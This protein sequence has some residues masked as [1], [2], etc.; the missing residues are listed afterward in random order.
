M[1]QTVVG[2]FDDRNDAQHAVRD[3]LDNKFPSDRI[4]IITSDPHGEFVHQKVDSE[5]GTHAAEG[6]V[7]GAVAG[8][9]VGG[10][11]GA[12]VGAGTLF[13]PPLGLIAAGPVAA[14]LAGAGVGAVG[15]GVLG[16]LIGLGIPEEHVNTYAEAIRRGSCLV[17]LEV[18]DAEV[19]RANEIMKKHGAVDVYQRAAYYKEQGFTQYDPNAKPYSATE[20]AQERQ[21]INMY[22]AGGVVNPP[23]TTAQYDPTHVQT[24]YQQAVPNQAVAYERW[25]P[26]Y[27]F[28]WQLAQNPQYSNYSQSEPTIRQQWEQ[29]NP[30]T[31]DLYRDAIY[32]GFDDA[33]ARR[34]GAKMM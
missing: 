6:A 8:A 21:N 10:V 25:E 13:F 11:F 4:S 31:Y 19:F 27:R 15:G 17:S 2:L 1:P 18:N 16:A 34:S 26:A 30:G 5:G 7:T 33:Y 24:R 20:I 3:F 9:I 29:A 28:G 22:N 32:A 12:L 23:V 14:A